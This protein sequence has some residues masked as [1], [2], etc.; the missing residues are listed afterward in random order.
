MKTM[1]HLRPRFDNLLDQYGHA[2]SWEQATARPGELLANFETLR[3][4]AG[5]LNLIPEKTGAKYWERSAEAHMID[6]R[7]CI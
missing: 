3:Q 4:A 7:I 2:P 1:W 6:A 5:I